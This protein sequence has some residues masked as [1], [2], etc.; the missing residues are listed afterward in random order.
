MSVSVHVP[1]TPTAP[2]SLGGLGSH[3]AERLD[4]LE[5]APPERDG[6]READRQRKQP[7][8]LERFAGE[9]V[10]HREH[11]LAE[12]DDEEQPEAL[13]EMPARDLRVP[14]VE[15]PATAGQPVLGP[16]AGVGDHDRQPPEHEARV[17]VGDRPGHPQDAGE[18]FPDQ[19]VDEM[20][21]LRPV[22]KGHDEKH[23]PAHL[24]KQVAGDEQPRAVAEGVLDRD[25]HEQAGEHQPDERHAHR[26]RVRIEPVRAPRDHVPGVEDGERQDDRLGA[27]TEIEVCDQVVRELADRDDVDE[28]EEQLERRDV[29]LGAGLPRDGDPH[30][31]MGM[32]AAMTVPPS[33]GLSTRTSGR[34]P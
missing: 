7:L 20:L 27:R 34:M 18:Q 3:D 9:P 6:P 16:R 1:H 12:R 15:P 2:A 17:A 5:I 14:E 31:P 33:D 24:Q 13:D 32:A 26:Q 30:R 25:G 11:G 21:A 19:V 29:A 28:V 22:A 4:P 23:A 8:E 10:A